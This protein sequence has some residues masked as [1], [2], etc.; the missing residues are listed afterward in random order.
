MCTVWGLITRGTHHC[1]YPRS[2]FVIFVVC[3]IS[4]YSWS[5]LFYLLQTLLSFKHPHCQ[6][7]RLWVRLLRIYLVRVP[8]CMLT[9]HLVLPSRCLSVVMFLHVLMAPCLH[10]EAANTVCVRNCTCI[11][12]QS[13][14]YEAH[15]QRV[16]GSPFAEIIAAHLK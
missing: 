1:K 8:L 2:N 3:R 12:V 5:G 11:H 4:Y 9:R 6:N 14:G 13:P 10:R 15:C 7:H 16:L